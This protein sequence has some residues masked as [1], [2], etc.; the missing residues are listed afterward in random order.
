MRTTTT[1][2]PKTIIRE[3][4]KSLNHMLDTMETR[5]PRNAAFKNKEEL[6][7]QRDET[8][9]RT[10]FSET[11]TYSHAMD[12]MRDGYKDPLEK[13]K[14]AIL[15]IGKNDNYQKPRLKADFVGFV[16][17]VPNTVMNLPI[18]MLNKQRTPQKTKTIHLTYNFGA[19]A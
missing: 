17:H 10:K 5:A 3:S 1:T 11:N 9:K 16:P 7:S 12:I 15:K 6:S 2:K 4:F 19:I 8:D 14:K 13:M 18:T